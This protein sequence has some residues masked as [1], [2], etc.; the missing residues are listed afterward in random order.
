M[1]KKVVVE[2]DVKATPGTAPFTGAASG[3]WTA[4][5]VTVVPYPKLSAGGK[6]V[7]YQASCVFNFA[8][9][10][11]PPANSPVSGSETVMLAAKK[12]TLNAGQS[13]VLVDGDQQDGMFG[14]KLQATATQKLTTA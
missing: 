1:G 8:G 7:I 11:P 13:F 6:K 10:S 3:T 12:T 4:G 9:T 2:G 5:P 14:N